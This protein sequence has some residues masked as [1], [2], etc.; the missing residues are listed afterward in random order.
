MAGERADEEMEILE[1]NNPESIVYDSSSPQSTSTSSLTWISWFCSLPGH[2]YF[3][4]VSEDFIED[5][6]NLTGLAGIVGF[7][8]EAL[9]MIL[10]VE[11][12]ES[13]KIPDVSIVEHSAEML[14]GLIHARFI[15][16]RVGLQQMVEKYENGHFGFCPRFCCQSC[17]VVPCGRSDTPGVDTVKLY[18]PNCM[19]IYV[20]PSSRF[21]GVDGSFFGT[22]FPHLLFHTYKDLQP[23]IVLPVNDDDTVDYQAIAESHYKPAATKIYTPKIYGFRISEKSRSGPRMQWL[24]MRPT[25]QKELDSVDNQGRIKN[26]SIQQ[27]NRVQGDGRWKKQGKLFDEDDDEDIHSES[28]E[29]EEGKATQQQPS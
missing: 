1:E 13:L 19:D 4:E 22:T 25:S 18:C 24:R 26:S 21:Q 7:Y 23:S 15:L 2:E 5:E 8:K 17:P 16:T 14:Y 11:P 9:E 12:E 28:D 27:F 29:E 6:F 20:P 3:A 10:D